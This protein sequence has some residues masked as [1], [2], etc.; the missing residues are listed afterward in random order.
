MKDIHSETLHPSQIDD[1]E[2]TTP[3]HLL[4]RGIKENNID[5]V[6]RLLKA[7]VVSLDITYQDNTASTYAAFLGRWETLLL[8]LQKI[9]LN[10]SQKTDIYQLGTTLL[11]VIQAI[12]SQLVEGSLFDCFL[13]LCRLEAHLIPAIWQNGPYN[14]L[15]FAVMNNNQTVVEQLYAATFPTTRQQAIYAP[16]ALA[17]RNG[18]WHLVPALVEDRPNGLEDFEQYGISLVRAAAADKKQCVSLLLKNGKFIKQLD[19]SL[20][21]LE[22]AHNNNVDMLLELIKHGADLCI[23]TQETNVIKILADNSCYRTIETLINYVAKNNI[24]VNEG[25]WDYALFITVKDQVKQTGIRYHSIIKALIKANANPSISFLWYLID[26]APTSAFEHVLFHQRAD[27]FPILYASPKMD[28]AYQYGLN[29]SSSASFFNREL[30]DFITP[31]LLTFMLGNIDEQPLYSLLP[32]EVLNIIAVLATTSGYLRKT[33]NFTLIHPIRRHQKTALLQ[34]LGAKRLAS[35]PKKPIKQEDIFITSLIQADKDPAIKKLVH[36]YLDFVYFW[37]IQEQEQHK[38]IID[39]LVTHHITTRFLLTDKQRIFQPDI[40]KR[41]SKDAC[42]F[43]YKSSCKKPAAIIQTFIFDLEQKHSYKDINH[44]VMAFL[45]KQYYLGKEKNISD[46]LSFLIKHGLT[47]VEFQQALTL[48]HE[49]QVTTRNNA[50]NFLKVYE[51]KQSIFA[52][53]PSNTINAFISDLKTKDHVEDIKQCVKA[54]LHCVYSKN[55]QEQ[56]LKKDIIVL[57]MDNDLTNDTFLNELTL[58]Y[59]AQVTA[60]NNTLLFLEAY[61]KSKPFIESSTKI[62]KLI[63]TLSISLQEKTYQTIVPYI[64][65][66]LHLIHESNEQDNTRE[67]EIVNLLISCQLITNKQ[68]KEILQFHAENIFVRNQAYLFEQ[69]YRSLSNQFFAINVLD[70]THARTAKNIKLCAFKRVENIYQNGSAEKNRLLINLLCQYALISSTEIQQFEEAHRPSLNSQTIVFD[71][72][73]S[74]NFHFTLMS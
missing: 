61:K 39:L 34:D 68:V 48:R 73:D 44:C 60:A 29:S 3:T 12:P 10:Y 56:P 31:R 52:R 47:T 42:I 57:L 40:L 15:Y 50:H 5:T 22:A 28:I 72:Q 53:K 19:K 45:N 38:T 20:S 26:R 14:P 64:D 13:Q 37:D 71:E 30:L 55:E 43:E 63:E 27:L 17:S 65:V 21:L 46:L 35:I 2:G 18:H 74:E 67:R 51:A 41:I 7:P 62:N 33:E 9:S 66:F 23:S 24:M 6:R 69:K 70:L 54:F 59:L 36:D 58:K 1:L 25:F 8:I 16:T 32:V 11:L 49:E 4:F